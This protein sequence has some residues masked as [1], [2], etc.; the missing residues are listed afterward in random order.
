M[1]PRGPRTDCL[2]R[3]QI[4][5]LEDYRYNYGLSV[6]ALP[7]ALDAPFK[8]RTMQKALD[9]KPVRS[10]IYRFLVEWID[11]HKTLPPAPAGLDAKQR[12]AGEREE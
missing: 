5:F 4:R 6:W 12:A 11:A 1:I 8:A 2:S 10:D 9:G 3:E 7:R